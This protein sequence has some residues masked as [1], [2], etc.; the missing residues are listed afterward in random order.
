MILNPF[1]KYS[2]DID[3]STLT[4]LCNLFGMVSLRDPN[5]KVVGDLQIGA[6]SGH[7]IEFICARV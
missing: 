5:S 7:L 4:I 6:Y 1:T 3:C 2:E